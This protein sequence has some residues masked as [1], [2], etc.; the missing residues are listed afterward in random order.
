MSDIKILK[1]MGLKEV[2]RKT[3]IEV[4]YLQKMVDKDF[5]SLNRANTLGFIRIL[6]REYNLDFDDWI[7]EF[8]EYLNENNNESVERLFADVKPSFWQN[9]LYLFLIA[10]F[11]ILIGGFLYSYFYNK[12]NNSLLPISDNTSMLH[13]VAENIETLSDVQNSTTDNFVSSDEE[14]ITNDINSDTHTEDIPKTINGIAVLKP[15]K[16]IW[17]GII[18]LA[19]YKR[20]NYLQS[21]PLDIDLTKEQL[22]LTGHGLFSL[23]N[24]INNETL[25]FNSAETKY[26][27]VKDGIIKEINKEEFKSLNRGKDW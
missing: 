3:Y 23:Q 11:V 22:I 4:K 19:D 16:K 24:N 2:S 20:Q 6:K 7:R 8:E 13:E 26:L 14:V 27:Y 18:D 25:T 5:E 1:E 21:T 10:V 9:K 15:D 17:I 12:S